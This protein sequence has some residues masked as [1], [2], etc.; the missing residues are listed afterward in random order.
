MLKLLR[1]FKDGF[2]VFIGSPIWLTIFILHL[3][4][5]IL[6]FIFHLLKNFIF[7]FVPNK[8][9]FTFRLKEDIEVDK[10]LRG[11]QVERR[12]RKLELQSKVAE[13]EVAVKAPKKVV[14][15][16]VKPTESNTLYTTYSIPLSGSFM[17]GSSDED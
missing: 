12:S 17:G 2:V 8:E 1:L 13:E 16:E 9:C 15:Q 6:L 3:L 7:I 4:Y 5:S 10:C 14:T 11:E